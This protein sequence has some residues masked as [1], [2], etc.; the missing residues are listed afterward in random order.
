MG[1]VA[2][3]LVQNTLKYLLKYYKCLLDDEIAKPRDEIRIMS[4]HWKFKTKELES[5][6]LQGKGKDEKEGREEEWF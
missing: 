5:Q 4:V 3:L 2:G 6:I 1:M